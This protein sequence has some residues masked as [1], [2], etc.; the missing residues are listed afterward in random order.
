MNKNMNIEIISENFGPFSNDQL[1]AQVHV[2]VD[3]EDLLFSTSNAFGHGIETLAFACNEKGEVQDWIEVAGSIHN[4][5][6]L[7]PGSVREVVSLVMM[8]SPRRNEA[9]YRRFVAH[10]YYD[11]EQGS[12]DAC[13]SLG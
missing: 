8:G 11:P 5:A 6:K 1:V 12:L 10:E 13:N 9:L 3:G 2:K 4:G 7:R